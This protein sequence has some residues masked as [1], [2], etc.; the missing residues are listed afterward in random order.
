[1]RNKLFHIKS[2]STEVQAS[3]LLCFRTVGSLSW[4]LGPDSLLWWP[5]W[6]QN[7]LP[8]QVHYPT[9]VEEFSIIWWENA[10]GNYDA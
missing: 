10:I 1:M 7:L 8:L 4:P 5:L 3:C 6:W 2:K 9:S